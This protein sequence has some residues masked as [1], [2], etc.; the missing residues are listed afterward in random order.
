LTPEENKLMTQVG[1]GTPMGEVFRRFW[2]PAMLS[3]E[4]PAPNCPPVH[5]R[6]LGED[7]VAFRDTSGRIGVLE[8][9]C[10]HRSANLYWGRNEEDGLRCVYHGW[11]YDVD[12]RCL[13]QPN[14]PPD[15][16]FNERIR[17]TAY[18]A[19]DRGGVIW[20]HMGPKELAPEIPDFE[21]THVPDAQRVVHKRIQMCNYLQN[22]E[23]EVDSSHAPFL[24]GK[25]GPDGKRAAPNPHYAD[26]TPVFY[27]KETDYGL[28]MV[29]RR[30][31]PPDRYYWRITPFMVPCY[32]LVAGM[33]MFTAAVPMDDQT[34]TGITVV[35]NP[36]REVPREQLYGEW[37]PVDEHYFPIQNKANDYLID[38]HAQRTESFTGVK[39]TRVQDMVVQEDQRGPI[40]DRTREHLGS[41][42]IAMITTRR[43]LLNMVHALQ[44]GQEPTQA[45]DASLYALRAPAPTVDR[46]IP[47]E[48]LIEKHMRVGSEPAV[49]EY[50]ALR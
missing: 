37:C 7:L 45:A 6:L 50:I 44:N 4:L 26:T 23:G 3:E 2:L 28:V 9:Y 31:A 1:P 46:G 11:K 15:K 40:T 49:A 36:E 42:D 39:G 47:W 18:P 33:Y 22:L 19:V 8:T 32:N 43:I 41:A 24:H 38:R 30:D 27:L 35:W 25:I 12:G 48:E 20:V 10:A 17:I 29:A 16:R 5:L 34:T 13:D 21:W 14:E